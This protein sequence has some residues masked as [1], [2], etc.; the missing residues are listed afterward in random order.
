MNKVIKSIYVDILKYHHS[1]VKCYKKEEAI[2]V[3]M[4][5]KSTSKSIAYHPRATYILEPEGDKE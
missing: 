1:V 2:V 5:K 3:I 4:G